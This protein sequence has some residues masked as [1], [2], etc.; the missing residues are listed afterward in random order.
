MSQ[1]TVDVF[2][3]LSDACEPLDKNPLS[4]SKVKAKLEVLG[5]RAK[6]KKLTN[7]FKHFLIF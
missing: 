1:C 5:E 3:A 4:P 6:N 2:N 7:S